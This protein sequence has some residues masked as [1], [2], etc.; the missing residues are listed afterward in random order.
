MASLDDS[1]E[2]RIRQLQDQIAEFLDRAQHGSFR[3]RTLHL[4]K[5]RQL[6]D[7]LNKL[8]GHDT[9][10]PRLRTLEQAYA[11]LAKGHLK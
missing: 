7:E 6:V 2:A 5:C 8:P 1:K 11:D 10:S 9:N 3:E 4:I